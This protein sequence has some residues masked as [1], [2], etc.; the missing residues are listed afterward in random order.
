MTHRP[1]SQVEP[2]SEEELVAAFPPGRGPDRDRV[3]AAE[4]AATR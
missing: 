1:S 4:L 2:L 3:G